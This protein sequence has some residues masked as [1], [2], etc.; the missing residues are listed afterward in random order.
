MDEKKLPMGK[1]FNCSL[2]YC[3]LPSEILEV[4]VYSDHIEFECE[5]GWYRAS[6]SSNENSLMVRKIKE[7]NA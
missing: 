4:A 6:K 3:E 5:D 2:G 1:F 7:K